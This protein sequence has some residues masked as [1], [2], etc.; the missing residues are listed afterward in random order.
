MLNEKVIL[1]VEELNTLKKFQDQY[2][3]ILVTLGTIEIELKN[4][5]DL[6]NQ[7]LL[8]FNDLKK[9]QDKF[10]KHLNEKY[11]EGTVDL[12]SG[13]FIKNTPK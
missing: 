7:S 10:G 11:G 1:A 13:E 8:N 3:Q 9:D 6:K 12:I 4:L 2:E 5:N